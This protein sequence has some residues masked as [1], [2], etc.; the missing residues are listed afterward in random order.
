[1]RCT[2]KEHGEHRRAVRA[3]RVDEARAVSEEPCPLRVGADVEAADV[4]QPEDR[5]AVV[6]AGTAERADLRDAIAVEAAAD[7]QLA[8]SRRVVEQALSI[9]DEARVEPADAADAADHLAAHR[10]HDLVK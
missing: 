5:D 10:R 9:D 8:R 2:A 7:T 6:V 1:P 3:V 4:L